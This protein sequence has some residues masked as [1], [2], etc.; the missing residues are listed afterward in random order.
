ML[1]STFYETYYE[2]PHYSLLTINYSLFTNIYVH[3]AVFAIELK[4]E[5]ATIA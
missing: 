3:L 2:I 1:L 5:A 4:G